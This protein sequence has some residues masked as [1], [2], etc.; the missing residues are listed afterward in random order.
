MARLARD[1]PAV[2]H[3]AECLAI[4]LHVTVRLAVLQRVYFEFPGPP[5]YDPN[6]AGI[7]GMIPT[8]NISPSAANG[9]NNYQY[10]SSVPQNRWEATGKVDYAISDN[11]KLRFPTP[12]RSK[13][14]SIR[15]RVVDSTVDLAVSLERE[16]GY[17]LAGV[18]VELHSRIQSDHHQR[19]CVHPGAIHQ[20]QH[21]G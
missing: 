8:S 10:I 2:E 15:R 18:H 16:C 1:Y 9:W 4:R 12:D 19:V 13:T 7:L 11:T 6:I 3:V 20:P 17:D 5:A 21:A 14:I